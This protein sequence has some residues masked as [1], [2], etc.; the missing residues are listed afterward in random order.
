MENHFEEQFPTKTVNLTISGD[1]FEL[2]GQITVPTGPTKTSD[3]LPLARALSDAVVSETCRAVEQLGET[4]S[5]KK[6]CGACCRQLIAIS[7]VEARRIKQIVDEM[8]ESRRAEIQARFTSAIQQLD[9]A[10]LMPQ[11]QNANELSDDEYLSIATAYFKQQIPCPFLEDESCSIYPERPITCREY[12]VTSPAE[13]C[14]QLI[15]EKIVRVNLPLRIYNAV[16][17]WQVPPSKHFLERWVPLIL[18]PQWAEA[19]PDNTPPKSG[20]ELLSELFTHLSKQEMLQGKNQ[21][22]E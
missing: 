2:Q 9:K 22:L 6:G 17:R 11:L 12:L 7:E 10:G 21:D 14:S 19:N 15:A 5:C 20:E 1:D 13:N 3:L 4:I 18:A 8:P 16:A